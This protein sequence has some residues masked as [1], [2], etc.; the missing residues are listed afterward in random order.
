MTIDGLGGAGVCG[1][2][3]CEDVELYADGAEGRETGQDVGMGGRGRRGVAVDVVQ[4]GRAIHAHAHKPPLLGKETGERWG[5]E[6]AVRLDGKRNA[7]MR[8][9]GDRSRLAEEV[10]A[11][12][13]R[14]AALKGDGRRS[15]G[16]G[17]IRGEHPLEHGG[18]HARGRG[19]LRT[20]GQ[21][22]EAVVAGKI[23]GRAHGFY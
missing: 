3:K 14:L 9:R 13:K 1:C 10:L 8:T 22:V 11:R 18:R 6:R 20:I 5:D 15:Q 19:N 16:F 21:T 4:S 17:Q 23:A 12:Q 7:P 2:D